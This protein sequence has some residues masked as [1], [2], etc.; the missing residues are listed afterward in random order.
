[1]D[2]ELDAWCA[3]LCVL[4]LAGCPGNVQL[5]K[6]PWAAGQEPGLAATPLIG[7]ANAEMTPS[8]ESARMHVCGAALK[9]VEMGRS[10]PF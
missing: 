9:T 6:L 7:P 1:V 8:H 10:L 5:D 2:R 3:L 4:T